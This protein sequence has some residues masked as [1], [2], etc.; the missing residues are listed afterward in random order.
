MLYQL[1]YLAEA[2]HRPDKNRPGRA[3][4]VRQEPRP[5]GL[6]DVR[7]GTPRRYARNA[8]QRRRSRKHS[9]AIQIAGAGFEPATFGL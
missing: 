2:R 5:V 6:A 7:R 1:S 3:G 8:A 4:R 9:V